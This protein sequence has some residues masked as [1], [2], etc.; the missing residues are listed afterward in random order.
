[1]KIKPKFKYIGTN[2]IQL[3]IPYKNPEYRIYFDLY[4]DYTHTFRITNIVLQ[5]HYLKHSSKVQR[6]YSE[7]FNGKKFRRALIRYIRASQH[8]YLLNSECVK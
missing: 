8:G 1:M 2:V 5:H 6:M 3:S 7:Y 4:L